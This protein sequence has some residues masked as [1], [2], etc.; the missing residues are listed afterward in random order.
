M[1]VLITDQPLPTMP[2]GG[3][4]DHLALAASLGTE[5]SRL[6]PGDVPSKRT[7]RMKA[8]RQGGVRITR[9]NASQ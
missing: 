9:G 6:S 4:D 8:G 2:Q 3:T 5:S 7:M 1:C